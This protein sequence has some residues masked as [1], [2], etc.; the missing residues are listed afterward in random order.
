MIKDKEISHKD[1]NPAVLVD[2]SD[3]TNEIYDN[4]GVI[5]IGDIE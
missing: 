2:Y 5:Y 4:T 1:T 3:N